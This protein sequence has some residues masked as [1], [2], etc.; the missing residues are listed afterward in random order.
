MG[1]A[2]QMAMQ[3]AP[4]HMPNKKRRRWALPIIGAAIIIVAIA[5]FLLY[6]QPGTTTPL[7]SSN[8]GPGKYCMNSSEM[9]AIWGPSSG[10]QAFY[11]TNRRT[12][13]NN[14][15]NLSVHVTALWVVA[16]S[17]PQPH[18]FIL[19]YVMKSPA[20]QTLYSLIKAQYFQSG[21]GIISNIANRSYGTMVYAISQG[22]GNPVP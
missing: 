1:D 5:V 2:S 15:G 18:G 22:G 20:P 12:I 13:I 14:T 7:N 4:A 17:P 8:C 3:T 21:Q 19:E 16:Y 10:Y 11:T 9:S 6:Q